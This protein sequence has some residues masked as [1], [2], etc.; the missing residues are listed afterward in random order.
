MGLHVDI[1]RSNYRSIDNAFNLVDGL[2]IVNVPG[3]STPSDKAP[4]AMLVPGHMRGDLIVV[5]AAPDD[6]GG[7]L[8]VTAGDDLIGPMF[9]GSFAYSSDSRWSHATRMYGALPIHDRF[10]DSGLARID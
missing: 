6:Q 2:T 3:P 9:G 4:A 10:E 7:W 8:R 1:F 5:A